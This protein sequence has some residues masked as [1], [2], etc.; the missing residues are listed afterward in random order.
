MLFIIDAQPKKP[1]KLKFTV[2]GDGYMY[3]LMSDMQGLYT[4]KNPF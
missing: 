4:Y 2:I 1:K 3:Y